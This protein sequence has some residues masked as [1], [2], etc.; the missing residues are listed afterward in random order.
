MFRHALK[1]VWNRRRANRL[2]VLEVAAAFIVTFVVAAFAIDARN[3][4]LRPLGFEYDDVWLVALT[5]N[6]LQPLMFGNPTQTRAVVEDVLA[7]LR[8]LPAVEA[9]H[10]IAMPP[11]Q[12][13]YLMTPLGRDADT[14]VAT[15]GN[16]MTAE[17][18]EMLGVRAIDGR[19][20]GPEDE[21][22]DYIATLVNTAFVEQAFGGESPVGKRV[23]FLSPEVLARAPPGQAREEQRE[24][25]VVGVIE[26]FR[27]LGEFSDRVP[28]SINQQ[29]PRDAFTNV[30]VKV[31]PGTERGFEADIVA[32]ALSVAPGWTVTVTP[33]AELRATRHAEALLPLKIGATLAAF[34]LAMVVL[35][36][37][38]I[39][40]QDVVRRTQEIGVRRAAGAA[41]AHVRRQIVLEMLVIGLFGIGAGALVAIQFPLFEISQFAWTSALPSLV[42]SAALIALLA[43]AAAFYPAWLASRREPTDA[44]RYE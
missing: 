32:A 11:F 29:Q 43:M 1:I 24:V 22:Q 10:G 39:V 20:F 7:R 41:S 38:G 8:T 42:V 9:A 26:D 34:L 40:W 3:D 33:L 27:Q 25:R 2:V 28:Y 19:L 21:G 13:F 23:N 31:A 17:G 35:G 6:N 14:L 5:S 36:L 37:I 16:V 12:N 44:L 18:L 15:Q 4:Y 30:L